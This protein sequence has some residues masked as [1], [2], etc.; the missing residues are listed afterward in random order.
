[1]KKSFLL[2]AALLVTLC[3][4]DYFP[5]GYTA[6][7]DIVQNP[8]NYQ[9]KEVKVK[10]TVSNVLKIPFVEFKV[11]TVKDEGGELT[12]LTDA[13]LPALNQKIAL[14][15]TIDSTAIVGGEAVG[16]KLKEVKRL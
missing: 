12:V 15:A 9:G 1:M 4:C 16:L 2:M 7:G 10:G 14:R 6:I 3:G 11:Y 13:Q 8:A 5:F